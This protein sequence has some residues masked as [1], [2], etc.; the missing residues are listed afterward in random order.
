MNRKYT[1]LGN[2][3]KRNSDLLSNNYEFIALPL[4]NF[5][6]K[7]KSNVLQSENFHLLKLRKSFLLHQT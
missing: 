5:N 1:R 4:Y 2:S 7:N 6:S 3:Q